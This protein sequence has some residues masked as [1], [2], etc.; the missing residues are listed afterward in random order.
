MLKH[1]LR[2]RT[3]TGLAILAVSLITSCTASS[4][5]GKGSGTAGPAGEVDSSKASEI[6]SQ[7]VG[8]LTPFPVDQ[9]LAKPLPSGSTIAY[10]QCSSPV[11]G[12]LVPL[13][14]RATAAMG[15]QLTVFNAGASVT[16]QQAALDSIIATKP[17][18]V[19]LPGVN[20]AGIGTQIQRMT[21]SGIAV[22]TLGMTGTDRYGVQ[23]SFNGDAANELYGKVLAA[24]AINKR[25]AKTNAVIY[26]IPEQS[27]ATRTTS[28]F[29]AEMKLLCPAC[30]ARKIDIPVSSIGLDSTGRIVT[31]L[32]SHPSSNVAVFSNMDSATGLP[33]ALGTAGISGV[34]TI[35]LSPSPSGLQDIK[36]GALT[37]GIATDIPTMV[38]TTV[39]SVARIATG[40]SLTAGEHSGI[41]PFQF[42]QQ[43]DVTFDP[44]KGFSGYRDYAQRFAQLWKKS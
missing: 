7:Y 14:K 42:L 10:M 31:D 22:A 28:S 4:H 12:L 27:F 35:G 41:P 1:G 43:R 2:R 11:C 26:E 29:L 37:G 25:G 39:D 24:Y 36:N 5:S 3:R 8:K 30:K 32:Q 17:A 15:V 20:P 38:W 40:Q 23:A 13:L 18:G 6:L 19:I 44:T 21:S 34:T 33:A 16:A 9:P